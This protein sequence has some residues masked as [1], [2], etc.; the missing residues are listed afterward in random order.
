ML[1]FSKEDMELFVVIA[2]KVWLRRNAFIFEGSFMHPYEV[3]KRADILLNDFRRNLSLD[4]E[5]VHGSTTTSDRRHQVWS[6][7]P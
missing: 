4:L 3:L 7:P 6:A 1:P 2:R 5:L